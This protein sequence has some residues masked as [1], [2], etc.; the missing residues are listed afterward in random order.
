MSNWVKR[1]LTA[2]ISVERA[3]YLLSH[4]SP[5]YRQWVDSKVYEAKRRVGLSYTILDEIRGYLDIPDDK[6]LQYESIGF[7]SVQGPNVR[8]F[9]HEHLKI[10][11]VLA[12]RSKR[13]NDLHINKVIEYESPIEQLLNN[14]QIYLPELT[15]C[16]EVVH[17]SV[18]S[19]EF[20]TPRERI[21]VSEEGDDAPQT[22]SGIGLRPVFMTCV[23]YQDIPIVIQTGGE[24]TSFVCVFHPDKREAL[25]PLWEGLNKICIHSSILK[26]L[27][28][29]LAPR[30]QHLARE[31]AVNT[32]D[33][34]VSVP[35]T[36]RL[37]HLF[38]KGTSSNCAV[39]V[40]S[41]ASKDMR[42]R[43]GPVDD[44]LFSPEIQNLLNRDLPG[45]IGQMDKFCEEGYDGRRAY[46]LEGPPGT[47]KSYIIKAI[48]S[49]MP[50]EFTTILIDKESIN[51]LIH[52]THISY[53]FPALVVIEDID[54]LLDNKE[55]KQALLNFLDGVF[56]PEKMLTI[57]TSNRLC[58]VADSIKD[59]PGRVD[60]VIKVEAG[61][62]NMRLAQLQ[63]LTR[64]VEMP[65]D[66]ETIS[67]KTEGCTV[68]Q[69][70]ELVR[71][72]RIYTEDFDGAISSD[73]INTVLDEYQISGAIGGTNEDSGGI[74]KSNEDSS[75]KGRTSILQSLRER[76]S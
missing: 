65:I 54:L 35:A 70:R 33:N 1:A 21:G 7:D 58:D 62:P 74:K 68:A 49:T 13:A 16:V 24:D 42:F 18:L 50:E 67:A 72:A 6:P 26:G 41:Q 71:R 8:M 60:R 53:L 2:V 27:V 22:P 5:Q 31:I 15:E 3:H 66:L 32:S 30:S 14:G 52:L 17:D 51:D 12:H 64:T 48:V 69:L 56:A 10:D 39:V 45:F 55:R 34:T 63:S 61:S 47:G 76:I 37:E 38:G 46:L 23:K 59:R 28:A 57:M 75:S 20:T 29:S 43:M 44:K 73:A 40:N 11:R 9:L 19:K 36:F 4:Y 25:M